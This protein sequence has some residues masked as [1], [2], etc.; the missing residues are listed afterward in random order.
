[1]S[2]AILLRVYI[3]LGSLQ[4]PVIAFSADTEVPEAIFQELEAE[5][6]NH[7]AN[8]RS[9]FFSPPYFHSFLYLRQE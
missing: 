7:D 8:N 1:M 3:W 2:G 5:G 6:F 4:Q 9:A